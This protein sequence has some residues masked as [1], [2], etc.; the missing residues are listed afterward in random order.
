MNCVLAIEKNCNS[1]F[2]LFTVTNSIFQCVFTVYLVVWF[3]NFSLLVLFI[4]CKISLQSFNESKL[5]LK[6][7][8]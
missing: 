1:F 4:Y 5:F 6:F 2:F 7:I 3:L 8:G